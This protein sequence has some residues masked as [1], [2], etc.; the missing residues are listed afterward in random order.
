MICYIDIIP[1]DNGNVRSKY[2]VNKMSYKSLVIVLL[3]NW[4]A[5]KMA[6]D[7][8]RN[9]NAHTV[10]ISRRQWMEPAVQMGLGVE[11]ENVYKTTGLHELQVNRS[12]VIGMSSVM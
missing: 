9:L 2:N 5:V 7:Y 12:N 10:L 11:W 6:K 4:R 8:A 1:F 3:I